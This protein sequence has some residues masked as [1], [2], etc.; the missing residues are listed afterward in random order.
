V[1]TVAVVWLIALLAG[2]NMSAGP[3]LTVDASADNHPIS[4]Y[5]YGQNFAGFGTTSSFDEN[6]WTRQQ[7]MDFAHQIGLT[8]DRWGGNAADRYNWKVGA[9]NTGSD[10]YYEN[11]PDCGQW[12]ACDSW[13]SADKGYRRFVDSD[14]TIGAKSLI[15]LPLP[16][17]VAKS[18][19]PNHPFDCSFPKRIFSSQDSFDQYDPN[20]GNGI[21][22]GQKLV[23]NPSTANVAEDPRT[24]PGFFSGWVSD[25][26]SRYGTAA[27]GGVLFYELGNEPG[28]WS[29]THR[30]VH[31]QGLTYDELGQ[32]SIAAAE[33]VKNSDASAQTIGFSE[34]GWPNYFCA[35]ADIAVGY[36]S[37]N[38]THPTGPDAAAHGSVPIVE[39][40][41]RQFRDASAQQGKR[42]L[43]Y[44]D[45]HYYT[46]ANPYDLKPRNP[47]AEY[48]VMDTTRSLWDPT[49][50]DPSWISDTIEL[51]PRMKQWAADD[52]PGTK[53]AL[54]EYNLSYENAGPL[55]NALIQAD[56]FGIFARE[57]LDLA[58]RWTMPVDG[59][60]SNNHYTTLIPW[61]F[62]L[63][64]DYDGQGGKFGDTWVR[65]Q[66]ADQGQLA[67]YAAKRS[68]DGALTVVVI[69]KTTDALTSPL[70]V[71][72]FSLPA[73]A[74]VFRWTGA[75]S[76]D[77]LA[78][79]GVSG[80]GFTTT[81]P[82]QSVTVFQLG[83]GASQPPPPPPPPPALSVAS[84]KTSQRGRVFSTAMR[85]Q[86]G[87]ELVTGG[88][89]ECSAKADN[90]WATASTGHFDGGTARCSWHVAKKLRGLRLT[91]F[92]TVTAYE[93]S[94]TRRFSVKIK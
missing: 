32:K 56:V 77:R 13:T 41:L 39:W 31:P 88:D 64:R 24:D 59:E 43:D 87:G 60:W 81:Y 30:D 42:L 12:D 9:W 76:I 45:V 10:F 28:L 73:K 3:A 25:L 67:V 82:G 14:R 16:G 80:P 21:D 44:V 8:V 7:G 66:S 61:A 75:Q 79:Q 36:E 37:C 5:I 48:S 85:A 55:T 78:D 58:T 92:E 15:T 4:P 23:A 93:A 35:Q 27:N 18:A 40:L 22:Q 47:D 53:T 34:W 2:G 84:F 17:W 20:C 38:P 49:F 1:P 52:Y 50:V 83:G 11:I 69:N 68:S 65:S 71:S 63:F 54:T 6:N 89:L 46:Q 86:R 74:R 26:V 19:K 94:V 29:D 91:G 90:V 72:G 62:R 70:S 33:A 51:I 57:G